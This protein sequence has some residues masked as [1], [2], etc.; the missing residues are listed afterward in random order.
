LY[1]QNE[2]TYEAADREAPEGQECLHLN[3]QLTLH[4]LSSLDGV[5]PSVHLR[6]AATA[7][8]LTAIHFASHLEVLTSL[9]QLL[10]HTKTRA[11]DP[12][13]VYK[14][15]QATCMFL[16]LLPEFETK[17]N[18]RSTPSKRNTTHAQRCYG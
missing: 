1:W 16:Q 17:L 15:F 5:C 3:V 10:R 14:Q 7:L 18:V 9:L 6:N 4:Q 11:Q 13:S 2:L 12:V 8:L